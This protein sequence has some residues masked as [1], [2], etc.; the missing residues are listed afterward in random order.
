MIPRSASQARISEPGVG[1][2]P[3]HVTALGNWGWL[4]GDHLGDSVVHVSKL[5]HPRDEETSLPIYLFITFHDCPP[6]GVK[7]LPSGLYAVREGSWG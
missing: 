5:F 6:G 1:R 7:S 4:A 2:K 3:V